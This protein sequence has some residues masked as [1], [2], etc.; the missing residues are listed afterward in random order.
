M[1]LFRLDPA[2]LKSCAA[3]LF[4]AGLAIKLALFGLLVGRNLDSWTGGFET[5]H[6]DDAGYYQ[7][8]CVLLEHHIF[9]GSKTDASQP[10]VFRTPGYPCILALCAA[11]VGTSPLALVLVQAVLL[12]AVPIVFLF[13]LRELHLR[14]EWT[15]LFVLDPLWNI[16]SLSLMTEDWLILAL[17]LSLFCWLRAEQLNWRF[18]SLF[19]F[20]LALLIKPTAQFFLPVFLGLTLLHF[21]RRGWTVCFAMVA[22]VPLVLWMWRNQAVC[23]EFLLSTQTDNQILAVKTIEAK[24]NGVPN[25]RLIE[26]IVGD[27]EREHGESLFDRIMDNKI[28][29]AGVMSAYARAH[30]LEFARYHLSGMGRILFGTAQTHI[31]WAFRNGQPFPLPIARGYDWFLLAWYAVLY[32]EVVWRF[33]ISWFRWPVGQYAILF[34]LYNLALIGVLAYTTGGGLKRMPFVPFIYLLLASSFTPASVSDRL[35]SNGWLKRLWP[36]KS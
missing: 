2:N 3:K 6:Y 1:H 17:L 16:L 7:T 36:G 11:V 30:P 26:H 31:V 19:I 34:T 20:C 35:R 15:W 25:S 4:V 10:T 8:T 18:A 12:S 29:F 5:R 24:Q 22:V 9:A 28:D 13:I 14:L 21:R 27:W 32:T 23:G 33:R